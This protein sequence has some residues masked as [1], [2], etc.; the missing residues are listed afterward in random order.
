MHRRLKI[1]W[2]KGENPI[3]GLDL[4]R[5]IQ[6]ILERIF[7]FG[8]WTKSLFTFSSLTALRQWPASFHKRVWAQLRMSRVS[9][10]AKHNKTVLVRYSWTWAICLM[11]H[12]TNGGKFSNKNFIFPRKCPQTDGSTVVVNFCKLLRD[13]LPGRGSIKSSGSSDLE[14]VII[15]IPPMLTYSEKKKP[16]KITNPLALREELWPLT[17]S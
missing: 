10:A 12:N 13:L 14:S 9:F 11:C 8:M 6:T 4:F 17:Y 2:G 1:Y 5:Y 3:Q 7:F 15:T 16:I